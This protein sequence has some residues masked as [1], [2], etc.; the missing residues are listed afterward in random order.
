MEL[1]FRYLSRQDVKRITTWQY[2]EP[3]RQYDGQR[4]ASSLR[5]YV[6]FPGFFPH[7]TYYAVDNEQGDLV[8]FFSFW[9]FPSQ[10]VVIGLGLRPDLT[11][12][13]HGLAFVQ[14]GLA[15]AKGQYGPISFHLIVA[16]F[17]KRAI[18]VYTRAGF[19]RIK[20]SREFPQKEDRWEMKWY[21]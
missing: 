8:G 10:K 1:T 5:M 4:I 17:N 11:G 15:F 6:W 19:K 14:A 7:L 12:Q 21:T 18:K 3:Y 16:P 2:D 13:G 9:R 20:N